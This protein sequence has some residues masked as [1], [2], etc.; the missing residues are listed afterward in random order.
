M[1]YGEA[2]RLLSLGF[3]TRHRHELVRD[4]RRGLAAAL[5]DLS[6]GPMVPSDRQVART[7][8]RTTSDVGD[9]GRAALDGTSVAEPRFGTSDIS[10]RNDQTVLTETATRRDHAVAPGDL[11]LAG[12][13]ATDRWPLSRTAYGWFSSVDRSRTIV[14]RLSDYADL[15]VRSRCPAMFAALVSVVALSRG[16]VAESGNGAIHKTIC[17]IRHHGDERF[18][19]VAPADYA[20]SKRSCCGTP[21]L[22]V[23]ASHSR[24]QGLERSIDGCS[25]EFKRS[26][27]SCR[28]VG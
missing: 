12:S 3:G 27:T 14:I 9:S 5:P 20:G 23:R 7:G 21:E 8:P 15:D 28:G 18:A 19:L 2:L 11:L 4:L 26:L 22:G 16:Q 13:W 24:A 25:E 1:R 17:C 6:I 10:L